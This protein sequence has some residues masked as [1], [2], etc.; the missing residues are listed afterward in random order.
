MLDQPTHVDT[1]QSCKLWNE[2]LKYEANPRKEF[3][4]FVFVGIGQSLIFPTFLGF[5]DIPSDDKT[6]AQE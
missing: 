2:P 3:T 4:S 6:W 1:G 5:A